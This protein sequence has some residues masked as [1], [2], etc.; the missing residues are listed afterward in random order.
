MKNHF[1][2]VKNNLSESYR[3]ACWEICRLL[4]TNEEAG[5]EFE[6]IANDIIEKFPELPQ[7]YRYEEYLI[8]DT[9]GNNYVTFTINADRNK[10]IEVMQEIILYAQQQ[11]VLLLTADYLY[12]PDGTMIYF[13]KVKNSAFP[14]TDRW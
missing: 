12:R 2:I 8:P 1:T 6:R 9:I 4:S 5:L 3:K 7:S 11:G 14:P 10:I 13:S